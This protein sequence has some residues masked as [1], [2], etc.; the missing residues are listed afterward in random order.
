MRAVAEPVAAIAA[1][2][3]VAV[4]IG[5][6][7]GDGVSPF[8]FG[9]G[10]FSMNLAS[11]VLAAAKRPLSGFRIIVDATGGQYEGFN[12]FGFGALVLILIAAH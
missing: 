4:L 6:G 3:C 9:F 7:L 5:L 2:S 12:Y 8:A 11:P 10:Y 1:L